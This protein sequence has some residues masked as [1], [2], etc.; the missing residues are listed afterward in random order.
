[1]EGALS[2]GKAK[3]P[4]G[5]DRPGFVRHAIAVLVW[6]AIGEHR[7]G[8]RIMYTVAVAGDVT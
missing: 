8:K 1:M 5:A 4:S 3:S 6:V 2:R 7:A